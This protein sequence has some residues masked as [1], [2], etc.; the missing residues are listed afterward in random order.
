[1]KPLGQGGLG[2]AGKQQ[3][4]HEQLEGDIGQAG[5]RLAGKPLPPAKHIAENDQREDRQNCLCREHDGSCLLGTAEE[6]GS[7]WTRKGRQAYACRAIGAML[8]KTFSARLD[9]RPE[10]PEIEPPDQV[11]RVSMFTIRTVKFL[12]ALM[13]S[14]IAS[15]AT[16]QLPHGDI[17]MKTQLT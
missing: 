10:A 17:D 8:G 1:R 14:R 3:R 5:R 13:S 7:H 12:S 4:R 16:Y 6:G 2:N 11:L 15:E 9:G